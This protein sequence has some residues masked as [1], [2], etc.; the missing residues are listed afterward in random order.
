MNEEAKKIITEAKNICI[1]PSQVNEPESL[2]AALALFYTLRELGKNVNLINDEFPEK[3]S[4]LVPS[5]DFLSSPKNF[6]ISV[7]REAADVSQ[8]YYE[9]TETHLK[10]HLTAD[11]GRLKKEHLSF[12]FENPKPDVVITLGI[13]DFQQELASKL[14]SFGFLL[15]A[16]II[17]IDNNPI[18]KQF[19]KIN[20]TQEQSLAETLLSLNLSE[21]KP[22]TAQALLAGM[23]VYYE[24]FK[25]I[26]TG[27][28]ALKT[29]AILMEQG[30]NY[31]YIADQ[32]YQTSKEQ[33]EFLSEI[34]KN[35][36][37]EQGSY[38]AALQSEKF[39]NFGETEAAGAM[40]KIKSLGLHN[41][42]LILWKSHASPAFIKGFFYSTNTDALRKIN[43]K[44][45]NGWVFLQFPGE[46]VDIIKE[47]LLILVK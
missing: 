35:V 37:S 8:I 16:P 15:D 28:G 22:E 23:V 9:K 25:N 19:G 2:S 45:K 24:N 10:I 3:L 4:F 18:N 46:N 14:D 40:E 47:K 11:R 21:T 30:A 43:G 13:Q 12:Y 26:K 36:K 33:M 34:F 1:I 38:V 42:L 44:L 5:L 27:P 41:N 29:A 32:I 39:W 17:N 20:L 7:P 31:Q 6:V